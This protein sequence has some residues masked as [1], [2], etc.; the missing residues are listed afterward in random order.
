M[1]TPL[2]ELPHAA[3]ML[4]EAADIMDSLGV[5]WWLSSGTA[6]G[7]VRD[8]GFIPH[9]TDLDAETLGEPDSPSLDR[10][11]EAFEAA[12][13]RKVRYMPFQRALQKRDV[14]F[15]VY[16]FHPDGDDLIC[17]TEWGRMRQA[18]YLF[19]TPARF[20]FVGRRY[21]MPDP[22]EEYLRVRFGED[23][24]VPKTSKVSGH[25]DCANIE[26]RQ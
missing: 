25:L 10:V 12:G 18:A 17:D 5:T 9:D 3:E 1:M 14:I 4:V 26:L 20:A 22:P 24:R 23:W 8:G 13:W 15:D 11:Q 2:S 6:L 19:A 16:F 7:F 21:P